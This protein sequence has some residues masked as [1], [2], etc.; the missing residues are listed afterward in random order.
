MDAIRTIGGDIGEVEAGRL[1]VHEHVLVGFVQD[2]KLTAAHY[3]AD[4]VVVAVAPWFSRLREAGCATFVDASPQYLGRD[5]YVLGR[6]AEMSG[7]RI[8]TNTGFYKRPYLP[9]WVEQAD[10][11]ELA[12]RW[13]RE[14]QDGIGQ[15]GVR[16]GFVKIALNDGDAIDEVQQTILRAAMRTSHETGL[17]VQCHTIGAAVAEHALALMDE[18]GFDPERFIWIHA[19]SCADLTVLRRLA[20]RGI[21]ISID[22]IQPG[23]YERHAELLKKLISLGIGE[24][25]LLSQDT[26]WYTVGEPGGGRIRPYHPLFTDFLPQAAALGLDADWLERGVTARPFRAMRLRTEA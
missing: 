7:I 23:T 1:L 13:V 4:E 5:P 22:S 6:L 3:D 21:W 16:P 19:Q 8:V 24:K 9:P 10:E 11:R 18:A 15:S 20:E 12:G 14:A 17:P 26:G 2:G 25:V